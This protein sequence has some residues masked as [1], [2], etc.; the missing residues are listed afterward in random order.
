MTARRRIRLRTVAGRQVWDGRKARGGSGF[1]PGI[2]HFQAGVRAYRAA[3]AGGDAEAVA[4]LGEID[5]AL[6]ALGRSLDRWRRG[7]AGFAAERLPP[8][9][10]A[11]TG[12]RWLRTG[13]LL[14]IRAAE[15]RR[16]AALIEAYDAVCANTASVTAACRRRGIANPHRASIG[17]RRRRLR[18]VMELGYGGVRRRPGQRERMPAHGEGDAGGGG[19]EDAHWAAPRPR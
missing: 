16:L 11:A 10:L 2:R 19:R 6:D 8:E 18:A 4:R 3:A 5:G 15:T 12:G 13:R 14:R 9:A 1:I 7:L 17:D